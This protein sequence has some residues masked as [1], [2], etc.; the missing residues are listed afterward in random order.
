[1]ED[2]V[3][4]PHVFPTARRPGE[5]L[6]AVLLLAIAVVLLVQINWQTTWLDGKGLAAQPRTWPLIGLAGMVIFGVAH[7]LT[8]GRRARTPGRWREALLWVSSL[9]YVGWYLIYVAAIPQLGYLASTVAFC[10]FLTWRTGYRDSR[11]L[12]TSAAFGIGVVLLF[13]AALHVR[14]PGGAIYELLPGALRSFMILN[15]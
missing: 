9:E 13:K 12:V 3:T 14:I 7:L 2:Q 1:M 11:A 8:T 5:Y 6:F 10:L 4:E 15:F